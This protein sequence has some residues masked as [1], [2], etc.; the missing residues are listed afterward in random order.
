MQPDLVRL[1]A[2]GEVGADGTDRGA[3]APAEAVA[4]RGLEQGGVVPRVAGVDE[5]RDAPVVAHPVGVLGA[6]YDVAPSADDRIALLD[7]EALEGIA[8][9]GLVAAGAEQERGRNA[10]AA[11]G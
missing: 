6:Q 1:V 5:G 2:V 4:A 3:Q 9:Y 11:V 8:A 7:A 10:L